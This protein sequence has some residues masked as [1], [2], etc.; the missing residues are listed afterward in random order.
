MRHGLG[1]LWVAP[2]GADRRAR[3]PRGEGAGLEEG[4]AAAAKNEH[5]THGR[6]GSGHV[7]QSRRNV[8]HADAVCRLLPPTAGPRS[9][10]DHGQ[11]HRRCPIRPE[12]RRHLS[13]IVAERE[14][15]RGP[16]RAGGVRAGSGARSRVGAAA[17][18]RA[19]SPWPPGRAGR[20]RPA[21]RAAP[22][23]AARAGCRPRAAGSPRC[24]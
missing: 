23:S 11:I 5:Q 8:H 1:F 15:R 2:T 4:P 9:R 24:R 10:N 17:W 22:R 7:G 14:W 20:G 19:A 18:G 13:M 12:C 16:T 21:C 6:E 3:E